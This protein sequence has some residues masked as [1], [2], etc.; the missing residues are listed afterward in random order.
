MH[1]FS[2][3]GGLGYPGDSEILILHCGR[4]IDRNNAGRMNWVELRLAERSL[5]SSLVGGLTAWSQIGVSCTVSGVAASSATRLPLH[6]WR[7]L[8]EAEDGNRVMGVSWRIRVG[9]G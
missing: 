6:F 5:G 9:R 2:P 4:E 3:Y 7:L 8:H 1:L